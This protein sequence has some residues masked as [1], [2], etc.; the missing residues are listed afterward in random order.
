M[1]LFVTNSNVFI[2]KYNFIN[3]RTKSATLVHINSHQ[4]VVKESSLTSRQQC[5]GAAPLLT[6]PGLSILAAEIPAQTTD[7]KI[8]IN[9][10]I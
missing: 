2:R 10:I 8:I 6:A 5:F 1:G 3:M 7:K 9:L 4:K